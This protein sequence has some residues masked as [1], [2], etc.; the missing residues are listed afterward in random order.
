MA[1]IFLSYE[2]VPELAALSPAKR[3]EVVRA[4][5]GR[6]GKTPQFKRVWLLGVV[7]TLGIPSVVSFTTYFWFNDFRW[8]GWSFIGTLFL[9]YCAWFHI[10]TSCLRPYIR[11]YLSEHGASQT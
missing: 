5:G 10:R 1:K 6:F 8:A 9:G 4:S 11:T 7:L 2:A 3:I